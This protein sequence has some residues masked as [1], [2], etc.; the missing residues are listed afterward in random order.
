MRETDR[1]VATYTV[2]METAS[3]SWRAY[4]PKQTAIFYEST[5]RVK[6]YPPTVFLIIFPT[7]D[8]FKQTFYMPTCI[9]CS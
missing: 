1:Q 4:K 5:V 6:N 7:G 8:N 9:V 2:V 3:V